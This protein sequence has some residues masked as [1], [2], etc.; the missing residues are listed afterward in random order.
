[1]DTLHITGPDN[2]EI[3]PERAEKKKATL[4][5]NDSTPPQRKQHGAA[6]G[7]EESQIN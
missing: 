1:L 6:N 7:N 5:V 3:I 2:K 4:V